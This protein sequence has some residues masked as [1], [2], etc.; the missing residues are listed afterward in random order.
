MLA[1]RQSSD[2]GLTLE[3][4][5]FKLFTVANLCFHSFDNTKA[6]CYTLPPTQHHSFFR[7]LHPLF[8]CPSELDISVMPIDSLQYRFA[9]FPNVNFTS[10]RRNSVHHSVLLSRVNSVFKQYSILNA[11]LT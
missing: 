4:S 1:L 11:I 8:M 3:T 7:N 9:S 10:L 5:A 2:E 6:P